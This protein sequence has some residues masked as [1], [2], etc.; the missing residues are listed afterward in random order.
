MDK[1]QLNESDKVTT[2]MRGDG[3]GEKL[4]AAAEQS[5]AQGGAQ[6]SQ[7]SGIKEKKRSWLS[8]LSMKSALSCPLKFRDS[9]KKMTKSQS[10]NMYIQEVPDNPKEV[11]IVESFRELL[12]LEG[13]TT[14][15]QINYHTLLRFLR[16]RDFDIPKAK[17]IFLN[18]LKWR[19]DYGVEAIPKEF[20]FDEYS[21]VKKY[22]PHGYHGVDRYGRPIYIDRLGMVDLNSLLQV[23]TIERLV[24]YH[25]SE[26]E[27]TQNLRYPACSIAAKRHVA[28]TT[29][30]LDVEGVGM[31][32]FSKPARCL[33]MEIQKI[34]SNYYPE[35]LHKLFVVNAGS[36]FRILWKALRAFLDARTL[37]KIKVLGGDYLNDLLEVIDPINLPSFLGG[38]CTCSDYGGCLFSDKGPWHNPEV[39]EMLQESSSAGEGNTD[40]IQSVV[41]EDNSVPIFRDCQGD[42]GTKPA[43]GVFLQK[44]H[45]LEDVLGDTKTKIQ[46]L[47]A[48]LENTKMVLQGLSQEMETMN[49]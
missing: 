1:R 8:S 4:R 16:M 34:D 24:R 32:N 14:G 25:V 13:H 37:A 31:S 49:I 30:I 46:A 9:L 33:F 43:N 3:E 45:T 41:P 20:S 21:E 23:T 26:Q 42:A 40:G 6:F 19:E 27:K 2:I 36:G 35:T 44:I 39:V 47:E 11:Q 12:F 29:S 28:S 15:K 48:A 10:I 18:Y 17:D 38:N 22:Y 7:V 5:F